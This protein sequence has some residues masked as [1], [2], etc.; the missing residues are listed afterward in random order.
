MPRAAKQ[1]KERHSTA[2]SLFF[3][4]KYL[5]VSIL[6]ICILGIFIAPRSTTFT[7][8][9]PEN[10]YYREYQYLLIA[11]SDTLPT[12]RKQKQPAI[13]SLN[14][15]KRQ[16]QQEKEL[17]RF[18]PDT[19]S[20]ATWKNLGFS[21][22]QAEVILKYRTKIGGFKYKEQLADCYMIGEKDYARLAP[23]I[24]LPNRPKRGSTQ[25]ATPKAK[26]LFRF[27]PDTASATTF[28]AIGFSERQAATLIHFREALGGKFGSPEQF[29]K[30][31]VVDSATL[32]RL[33][34]YLVFE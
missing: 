32:E 27:N 11:A 1:D 15:P 28:Q 8:L 19:A 14:P 9:F 26:A 7:S 25:N 18:N 20:L 4:Y 17:A 29:G 12:E 23:Y 6:L 13:D 21:A 3:H 24:V 16:V 31:Y 33:R 5:V 2:M 30:S 10:K 22:K 34:P